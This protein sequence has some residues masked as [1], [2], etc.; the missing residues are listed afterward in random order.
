MGLPSALAGRAVRAYDAGMSKVGRSPVQDLVGRLV[1]R[2]R[3]PW[4]F[5]LLGALFV[6]DLVIP[7][8]IP[9]I[10][11]VMLALLTFL[12]GSWRT[13]GKGAAVD[14]TPRVSSAKSPP[15]PR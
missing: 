2:M 13:R 10:D 3:Y 4:V 15:A 12:V 9:F 14:A 1:G 6:A 7:D 5:V 8:P 11:E